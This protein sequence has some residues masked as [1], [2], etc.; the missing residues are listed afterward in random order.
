VIY[1]EMQISIPGRSSDSIRP[2]LRAVA[3]R[4]STWAEAP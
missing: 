2:I 3:T 4:P 1:K